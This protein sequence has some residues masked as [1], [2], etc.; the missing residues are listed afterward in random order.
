MLSTIG[1]VASIVTI[2]GFAI[3][4]WQLFALKNSVKKSKRAIREVLDDKEY[5]KLKHI[6]EATENQLKEV[7]S[8]LITVDKQ[9]VNQKSIRERCVNVCS[10]LNKCYISLRSG[11]SYSNIKNQ[12]VEARNHMESFVDGELKSKEMKEARAFLENAM[13]GI[14]KAEGEFAERKVQAATHRN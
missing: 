9:G 2:V 5:E 11:E 13:E 6:L 3:T 10:E 7:S 14:K 8:L 4:I 1:N 12:F